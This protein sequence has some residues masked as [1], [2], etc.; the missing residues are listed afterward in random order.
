MRGTQPRITG[1]IAGRTYGVDGSGIGL[2]LMDYTV[3]GKKGKEIKLETV[4]V[5]NHSWI[6]LVRGWYCFWLRV[7][8]NRQHL[9][10]F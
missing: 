4:C 2:A 8:K 1:V 9:K 7:M 3:G 6:N 5:L 10:A